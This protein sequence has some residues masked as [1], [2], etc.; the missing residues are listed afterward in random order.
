MIPVHQIYFDPAQ[1]TAVS[2]SD[3]NTPISKRQPHVT[4]MSA[5]MYAGRVA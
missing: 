3:S 2:I 4:S 5:E 1:L